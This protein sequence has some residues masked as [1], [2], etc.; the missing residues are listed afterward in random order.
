[1]YGA[2]AVYLGGEYF[3]LRAQA[4]NFTEESIGEAVRLADSLGKKIY[5]TVNIIARDNDLDAIAKYAVRLA[6]AG[7]HG[8]II[9][10]IGTFMLIRETVPE[11]PVHV[12]T[13]ANNLNWRTVK[14]WFDNGASR[15]NLARE[16]SFD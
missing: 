1:M 13:Q 2:D 14:F 10:D 4:D 5:V 9:A 12:S 16:L 7:V 11:L 3:G 6:E 15:V 8:V